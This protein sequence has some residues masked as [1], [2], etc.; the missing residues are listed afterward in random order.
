MAKK[1]KNFSIIVAGIDIIALV[2]SLLSFR[3]KYLYPVFSL[4]VFRFVSTLVVLLIFDVVTVAFYVY[5]CNKNTNPY[6][7][8]FNLILFLPLTL[9]F[10][11]SV[12]YFLG[13]GAHWIS[14][15]DNFSEFG[16]VDCDL[17]ETC[18]IAGMR[19]SEITGSDLKCV[20]EFHY[21]YQSLFGTCFE[22][23]GRFYFSEDDYNKI[24]SNF[25]SAKEFDECLFTEEEKERLSMTGRFVFNE[26]TPL[27]ESRTSFESWERCIIEFNDEE[28][29]F[30][31]NLS[32]FCDT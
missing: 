1:Y 27:Y 31:F 22:F 14:Q 9:G 18:S 26:S 19:I 16:E 30:L 21:S 24:K 8:V 13:V 5:I 28:K 12:F 7:K 15:T 20:E 23:R 29:C 2:W 25:L 3:G 11:F 6:A 17:E 4:D 10:L 32:G